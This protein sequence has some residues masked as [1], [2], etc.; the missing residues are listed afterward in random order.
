MPGDTVF[1]FCVD[2][3]IYGRLSGTIYNISRRARGLGQQRDIVN[4]LTGMAAI[5]QS[6]PGSG[7]ADKKTC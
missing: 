7:L 6:V 2:E 5:D 3:I 1:V 4:S